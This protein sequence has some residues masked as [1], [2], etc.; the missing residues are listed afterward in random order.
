MM[1]VAELEH[2]MQAIWDAPMPPEFMVVDRRT[3]EQF[4]I[5][6]EEARLLREVTTPQGLARLFPALHLY[7]KAQ[8]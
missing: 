3:G 6:S 4:Q 8:P 5:V 2:A 7:K 1:T